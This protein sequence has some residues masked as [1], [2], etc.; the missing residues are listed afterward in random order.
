MLKTTQVFMFYDLFLHKLTFQE[1]SFLPVSGEGKI[2]KE[3]ITIIC[4]TRELS[5]KICSDSFDFGH[6]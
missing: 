3:L 1:I 4:D 6:F 2:F 5:G